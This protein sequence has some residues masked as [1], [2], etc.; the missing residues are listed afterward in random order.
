MTILETEGRAFDRTTG[1]FRE[2]FHLGTDDFTPEEQGRI[3]ELDLE[4]SKLSL[5]L[6]RVLQAD[7]VVRKEVLIRKGLAATSLDLL[8]TD[9][10]NTFSAKRLHRK[11]YTF[12]EKDGETAYYCETCEIWTKGQPQRKIY[13]SEG[14]AAYE[15]LVG[16]HPM[17]S[18][19]F[20][21]EG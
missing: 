3:L 20:P 5:Q 9:K 15:C 6:S 16:E 1:G 19:L 17:G 11:P 12:V 21:F 7:L 8:R 14:M 2:R 10:G 18:G 4:R 13:V